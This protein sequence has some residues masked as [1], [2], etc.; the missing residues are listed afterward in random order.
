MKKIWYYLFLLAPMFVQSQSFSLAKILDETTS[1]IIYSAY[2][3]RSTGSMPMMDFYLIEDGHAFFLFGQETQ[4]EVGNLVRLM[5]FKWGECLAE[6][7]ENEEK[8]YLEFPNDHC[9]SGNNCSYIGRSIYGPLEIKKIENKS[10]HKYLV[11][12]LSNGSKWI[13]YYNKIEREEELN[14]LFMWQK[15]DTI[16]VILEQFGNDDALISNDK[17]LETITPSPIFLRGYGMINISKANTP[18]L[19]DVYTPAILD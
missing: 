5:A 8:S 10:K 6:N 11:F 12:T 4:W 9:S 18:Y 1:P 2:E 15:G 14:D 16:H 17:I 7:L 3:D 19:S 13:F